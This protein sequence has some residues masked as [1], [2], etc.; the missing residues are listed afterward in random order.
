MSIRYFK[1]Q[2]DFR[3]WLQRNHDKV[4]ELWV[5]LRKKSSGIPT[6]SYKEALDEALCFGWID[7]LRK[8]VDETS[9]KIRFTPRRSGSIWSRINLKRAEELKQRGLMAPSGL[10]EYENRDPKKANLYSFENA[11]KQLDTSLEKKFKQNRKARRFFEAQPPY[12]KRLMIFWIMDAKKD[13]TRLRRLQTL[14]D[15]S[16]RGERLGIMTSKTTP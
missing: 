2:A 12:Y 11:P 16:A 9:Y 1:S 4:S 7:G 8:S 13:E 10:R 5:G 14:I 15:W 6:V 3:K